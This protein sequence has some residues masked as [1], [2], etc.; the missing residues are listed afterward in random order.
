MTMKPSL[1]A[2]ALFASLPV[3]AA[4]PKKAAEA[5]KPVATAP[6]AE[7]ADPT[8]AR[9]KLREQHKTEI[10]YWLTKYDGEDL[11]T[12]KLRCASPRFPAVSKSNEEISS[13]NDRME[14][15]QKCYNAFAEYVNKHPTETRIPKDIYDLMT[16]EEQKQAVS[17]AQDVQDL[18]IEAAASNS[19]MVTADFKAWRDATDAWV[20]ENNITIKNAQ[21]ADPRGDYDA[22]R[23]NYAPGK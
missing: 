15:W 9:A 23:N 7:K 21:A 20:K 19:K 10:D 11:R 16:P 17:H 22:R 3:L 4:A 5:P 18:M 14:A 8:T 13:L 12:G 2:L 1:F 6:V